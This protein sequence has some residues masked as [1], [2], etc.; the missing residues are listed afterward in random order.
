[1]DNILFIY[2]EIII[3]IG[4]ILTLLLLCLWSRNEIIKCAPKCGHES[5]SY[6]FVSEEMMWFC[7]ECYN[8]WKY[9]KNGLSKR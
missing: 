1:M 4:I 3:I 6:K 8:E 5:E 7:E 2:I 9:D